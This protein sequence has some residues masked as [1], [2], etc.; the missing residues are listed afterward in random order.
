MRTEP[1]GRQ[2]PGSDDLRER[3]W[4]PKNHN[5]GGRFLSLLS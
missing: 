1:G 5:A 2:A 4:W 3:L